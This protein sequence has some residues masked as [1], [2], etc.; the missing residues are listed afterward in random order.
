M[1]ESHLSSPKA[2]TH[3]TFTNISFAFSKIVLL[4][5]DLERFERKSSTVS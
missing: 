2:A 5:K 1:G 4:R 3:W